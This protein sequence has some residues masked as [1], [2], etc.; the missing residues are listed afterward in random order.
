MGKIIDGARYSTTTATTI[1]EWLGVSLCRSV[2]KR[3]LFLH[4]HRDGKTEYTEPISHDDAVFMLQSKGN[5]QA[6]S[7]LYEQAG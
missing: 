2:D 6:I 3:N 5:P 4:Y 7:L 1:Y